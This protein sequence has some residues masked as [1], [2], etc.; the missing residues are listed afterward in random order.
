MDSSTSVKTM[1]TN[2]P[3][4]G[5]IDEIGWVIPDCPF[6][7]EKMICQSV[8]MTT[9]SD[10]VLRTAEANFICMRDRDLAK[11]GPSMQTIT[12]KRAGTDSLS[13]SYETVSYRHVIVH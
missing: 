10:E 4:I 11:H 5:M 9:D 12:F 13:V 1:P 8:Q 3:F 6:C 7:G 2:E